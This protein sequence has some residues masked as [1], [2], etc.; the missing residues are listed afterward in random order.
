[1]LWPLHNLHAPTVQS[2]LNYDLSLMQTLC[3]PIN[4]NVLYASYYASCT[5]TKSWIHALVSRYIVLYGY[6]DCAADDTGP[7]PSSKQPHGNSTNI[8]LT[9]G[10]K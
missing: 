6:C 7:E 3:S 5:I 1:M 8:A 9:V 2:T 10:P 4:H